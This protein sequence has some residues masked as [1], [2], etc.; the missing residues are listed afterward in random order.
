ME[1]EE[2]DDITY[3]L[4]KRRFYLAADAQEEEEE[5]EDGKSTEEFGSAVEVEDRNAKGSTAK[6]VGV[7]GKVDVT[8]GTGGV[9]LSD[10][11]TQ[12]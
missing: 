3:V 6:T 8:R 9:Q 11:V 2:E 10:L 7:D 4:R 12:L 5:E 1:G